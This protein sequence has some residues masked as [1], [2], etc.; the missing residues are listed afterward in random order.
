MREN[1]LGRRKLLAVAACHVDLLQLLPP[2]FSVLSSCAD[3][4][5]SCA[6]PIAA[7]VG[8]Q[9][10][11]QL[12]SAAVD[13]RCTTSASAS[14][15]SLARG[16][17]AP[18]LVVIAVPAQS[19]N[20]GARTSVFAAAAIH[21]PTINTVSSATGGCNLL[22]IVAGSTNRHSL[23]LRNTLLL[24]PLQFKHSNSRSRNLLAALAIAKLRIFLGTDALATLGCSR[25]RATVLRSTTHQSGPPVISALCRCET[26]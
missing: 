4:I 8:R 10:R 3:P 18:F 21:E 15:L 14:S 20:H 13:P 19:F 9:L 17:R 25:I 22:S 2:S 1:R 11:I 12:L 16:K 26:V 6:D 23:D 5:S 24:S 7:A